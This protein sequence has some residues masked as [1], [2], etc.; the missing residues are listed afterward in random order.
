MKTVDYEAVDYVSAASEMIKF[1]LYSC[2]ERMGQGAVKGF[3]PDMAMGTIA[4]PGYSQRKAMY[5]D[6]T[7]AV[8]CFTM[9]V[10]LNGTF[11]F[12]DYDEILYGLKIRFQQQRNDNE[13]IER[14]AETMNIVCYFKNVWT[15]S[16]K[17]WGMSWVGD[18]NKAI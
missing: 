2:C 1:T 10:P 14:S 6:D 11:G 7:K 5:F 3:I 4:D 12:C 17:T 15:D 9:A 18:E 16:D 13:N 8:N